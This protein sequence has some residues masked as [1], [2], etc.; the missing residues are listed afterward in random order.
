MTIRPARISDIAA[1]AA[2]WNPVIRETVATFNDIEK[3][4]EMLAD[5]L[6]AKAEAGYPFLVSQTPR[7]RIV[8]FGT[9]GRFRASNGYR[10][11]ME[12]TIILRSDARGKGMGRRMMT[13]LQ[14]HARAARVHSMFA[15]ISHENS[16]AI[17]FHTALGYREVARLPEVGHKFDRW[18]DLVLMQKML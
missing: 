3:T 11:T 13:A 4:P 1:I 2:I 6:A 18:F 7:A 16:G 5:T 15:C 10:H 12:H 9:Y 14:D 17:A 8:G